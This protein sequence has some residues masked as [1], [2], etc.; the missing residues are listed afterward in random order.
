[1]VVTKVR[2]IRVVLRVSEHEGQV[3]FDVAFDSESIL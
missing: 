2:L 1:M 3:L